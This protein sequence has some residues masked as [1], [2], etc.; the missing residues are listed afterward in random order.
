MAPAGEHL[1]D[2]PHDG[3]AE[4]KISTMES[5]ETSISAAE[6]EVGGPREESVVLIRESFFG[7]PPPPP[8][9]DYETGHSSQQGKEVGASHFSEWGTERSDLSLVNTLGERLSTTTT[10]SDEIT[11]HLTASTL[12]E[13]SI[14]SMQ[15]SVVMLHPLAMSPPSLALF[16]AISPVISQARIPQRPFRPSS[17]RLSSWA[18]NGELTTSRIVRLDA[19]RPGTSDSY[20][21]Q[22]HTGYTGSINGSQVKFGRGR[23]ATTE[24]VPRPSDDPQDPLVSATILYRRASH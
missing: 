3:D 20:S 14:D 1:S 24:L 23:F 12:G 8:A 5:T 13:E 16:P 4:E 2:L 21:T 22:P 9:K 11:I 19:D 10:T 7:P 17:L 6:I 18:R 15:R